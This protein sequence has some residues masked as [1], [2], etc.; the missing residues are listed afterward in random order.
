MPS[1]GNFDLTYSGKC[2]GII[3]SYKYKSS[4]TGLQVVISEID[5][6]LVEGY[7]CIG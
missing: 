5:G 4:K 3:Q 1:Y 7:L 2:N 6:P